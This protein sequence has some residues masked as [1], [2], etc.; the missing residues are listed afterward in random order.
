VDIL[1]K[2][3]MPHQWQTDSRS[4]PRSPRPHSPI[5]L[6]WKQHFPMQQ[7][8][9]SIFDDVSQLIALDRAFAEMQLE[10]A[11]TSGS[12]MEPTVFR[13]LSIR[14]LQQGNDREYVMEEVCRLGMLLFLSP[15]W[16]FMGS[17]P[18]WT[19]AFTRNLFSVLNT[20]LLEWNDLRPLL[21]WAVYFAAIETSDI[22]ERNS[23]IHMLAQL[24]KG[25]G[26]IGW[27]ELMRVVKGVLW[28]EKV[29]ANSENLVREEVMGIIASY[30]MEHLGESQDV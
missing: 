10:A 17:S 11:V 6:I 2:I 14:P 13:L 7:S 8:W 15:I 19:F 29:F 5:S 23:F 3:A 26:L 21:I 30:D 16:R 24:M 1:P 27:E 12:W 22:V 28:V 4:P 20:H 18:V 9:I 25:S